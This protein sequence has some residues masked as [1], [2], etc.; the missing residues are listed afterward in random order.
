MYKNISLWI[1][2]Y[3][4]ITSSFLFTS[5]IS[6]TITLESHGEECFMEYL[7]INDKI[8]GSFEVLSGGMRDVDVTLFNAVGTAVYSVQ[9]QSRGS[10]STVAHTP[11]NFRLCFSNRLSTAS[12]KNI[13]FSLHLGDAMYKEIAKKE[14]VSALDKETTQL[15]EAVADLEDEQR[16][17]WSREQAARELNNATNASV[18]WYSILEFITMVAVGLGQVFAMRGY[19]ERKTRY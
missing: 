8:I 18:G 9:R 2:L 4:F 5:I 3:F 15:A 13:A 1:F 10:F 6:I 16:Y 12:E 17:L 14:H 7:D 11:G 19:F